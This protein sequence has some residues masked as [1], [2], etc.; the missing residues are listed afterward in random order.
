M[1]TMWRH[2]YIFKCRSQSISPTLL[3]LEMSLRALQMWNRNL[4]CKSCCFPFCEFVCG[5]DIAMIAASFWRREDR[6]SL[7]ENNCGVLASHLD[8]ER[9]NFP[10]S[11]KPLVKFHLE[12]M[13]RNAMAGW[14]DVIRKV[15][16]EKTNYREVE[17]QTGC[18]SFM[19]ICQRKKQNR[20]LSLGLMTA[21]KLQSN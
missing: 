1:K 8:G 17:Q 18:S 6:D 4:Q 7:Y 16:A 14:T 15:V 3:N 5:T 20:T 10:L 19:S 13:G 21:S 11:A 9:F 2:A 12:R